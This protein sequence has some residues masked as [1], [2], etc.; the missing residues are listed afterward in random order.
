MFRAL[1]PANQRHAKK[2]VVM[3]QRFVPGTL[4]LAHLGAQI[5]AHAG[6]DRAE[7]LV[8]GQKLDDFRQLAMNSFQF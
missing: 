5:L 3:Q 2:Q 7:Q 4:L 6:I 1:T 8:Q